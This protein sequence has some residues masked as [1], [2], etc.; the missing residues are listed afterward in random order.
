MP[1]NY[2]LKFDHAGCT[3]H[4]CL[5]LGES[6]QS[7]LTFWVDPGKITLRLF[8]PNVSLSIDFSSFS[9]SLLSHWSVLSLLCLHVCPSILYPAPHLR[10]TTIT[11]SSSRL[12]ENCERGLL[13]WIHPLFLSFLTLSLTPFLASI[14]SHSLGCGDD[15]LRSFPQQRLLQ[16]NSMMG[17]RWRRLSF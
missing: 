14:T 6:S 16:T 4:I 7:I 8:I 13:C 9:I 10:K 11:M 3:C 5:Y 17:W 1:L 2:V 15:V 12:L